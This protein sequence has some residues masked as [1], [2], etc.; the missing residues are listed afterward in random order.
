M[1]H[2]IN[3]HG[4]VSIHVKAET[5]KERKLYEGMPPYYHRKIIITDRTG[6]ELELDLF[7]ER[8]G[9]LE[10]LIDD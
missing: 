7:G 8:E 4:I 6:H 1:I 9:D 2:N 10:L 5:R 3:I